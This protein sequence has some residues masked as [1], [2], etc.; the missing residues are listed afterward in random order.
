MSQRWFADA[1]FPTRDRRL[2]DATDFRHLLLGDA[3]NF[4]AGVLDGIHPSMDIQKRIKNQPTNH[5][6]DWIPG[7]TEMYISGMEISHLIQGLLSA[8]GWTQEDLAAA[9][10][11]KQ[12]NVSRWLAGVEPRGKARDRIMELA[13]ESGLIEGER[14]GVTTIAIMGKVGAGAVIDPDHEQ[15]PP[16]GLEQ[17]ELPI[18][19][20]DD[21]IGFRVEG[22]SMLPKYGDGTVIVVHRGQVQSVT[23]L[24]GEE[25]AVLTYEGKRYLKT[26]KPGSARDLYNLE[27][28]NSSRAITGV[29]I[30]WA[31][32]IVA[33]I[34][35]RQVRR[36][37]R[38]KPTKA[39]AR[40][41]KGASR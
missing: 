25:V 8:R 12:N 37:G 14:E 16:E 27:S 3:E 22:D 30:R 40:S 4:A 36:V 32:A 5:G 18:A 31:S 24:V 34:P 38:A 2:S 10:V 13:R 15:V 33:I 28:L 6:M 21:V 9:V 19:I 1:G 29:R 26:L 39:A 20:A 17:V 35:P 7:Y 41:Q 11:T 23:S